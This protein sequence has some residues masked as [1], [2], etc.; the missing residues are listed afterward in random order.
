MPSL[1]SKFFGQVDYDPASVVHFPEGLPG[2]DSELDFLLLNRPGA[3]PV[4]FLQS[5]QSAGL[6]FIALPV[7]T[8]DKDYAL[9][10]APE[11]LELIGLHPETRPVIGADIACLALLTLTP[12]Q[13]PT[14]NLLS[15]VAIN[16]RN[17]MA[18]QLIQMDSP[19]SHRHPLELGSA[20]N[21]CS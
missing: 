2:F 17:R 15:P 16:L 12:G 13:P 21:S 3:E 1:D 10:A 19:Y 6:C 11:E 9:A 5:V 18:V 7:L 20:E 14:A 8:I 4:V